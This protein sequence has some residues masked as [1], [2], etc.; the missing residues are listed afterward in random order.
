MLSPCK[1]VWQP[2]RRFAYRM[3]TGEETGEPD[4]AIVGYSA[5]LALLLSLSPYTSR[6]GN[7]ES[8]VRRQAAER[9]LEDGGIY[10]KRW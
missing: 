1:S 9:H 8:S 5:S 4:C 6:Y 3:T 7:R 2:R 10:R